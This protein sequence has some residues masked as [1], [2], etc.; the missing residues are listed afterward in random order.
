MNKFFRFPRWKMAFCL[1]TRHQLIFRFS[2]FAMIGYAPVSFVF[3]FLGI[4][5]NVVVFIADSVTLK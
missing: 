1:A 2:L 4:C 5:G 3:P